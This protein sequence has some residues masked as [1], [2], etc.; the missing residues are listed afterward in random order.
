MTKWYRIT[1]QRV[2]WDIWGRVASYKAV[3]GRVSAGMTFTLRSEWGKGSS[4]MQVWKEGISEWRQPCK[5]LLRKRWALG[6]E[7]HMSLNHKFL[8]GGCSCFSSWSP[9][10]YQNP[11]VSSRNSVKGIGCKLHLS[12]SNEEGEEPDWPPRW[13]R[14]RTKTVIQVP[15]SQLNLFPVLHNYVSW[16]YI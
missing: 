8:E 16:F 9:L 14:R 6:D 15:A 12:F 10:Q 3:W 4:Q 7:L 1:E 11:T 2:A 5:R 13:V